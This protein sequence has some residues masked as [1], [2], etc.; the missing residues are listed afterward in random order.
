MTVGQTTGVTVTVRDEFGNPVGGVT[1]TLQ[2]SGAVAV[3][4]A[5]GATGSNGQASGSIRAATGGAGTV[6]AA[7]NGQT[8]QAAQ[9]TVVLAGSTTDLTA[10]PGSIQAGE[11]VT[12]TASVSP[13]T[14][15]GSV[16][17]Q[18]GGSSCA[19]GAALGP[20][21]G[22]SSGSAS[23]ST[24]SLAAGTHRI[25]ACYSGD[26]AFTGSADEI[27]YTVTAAQVGTTTTVALDPPSPVSGQSVVVNVSVIGAADAGPV[28]GV[29]TVTSNQAGDCSISL[30]SQNSCA[31]PQVVGPGPL[32]VNA[33]YGGSPQYAPSSGQ[34]T[35]QIAAIPTTTSI[36]SD[37]PDPSTV[38]AD[39]LVAFAVSSTDGTP[40]GTVRVTGGGAECTGTLTDGGG[41]CTLRPGVAGD[42]V[43]ITAQYL[44]QAPHAGSSATE[45]HRVESPNGAPNALGDAY[46]TSEDLP[47]SI[48]AAGVLAND[49]D[50]EGDPL[51]AV[52][53]TVSANGSLTLSPAGGFGY[54]PAADFNGADRFTYRAR[55]PAGALSPPASV[56]LTVHPVNDPP[57]FTA[58]GDVSVADQ[59]GRRVLSG[60]ATA[61][62]A[63]PPDE[64]GQG[65]AFVVSTDDDAAF[66]G[67]P[68]IGADGTL[69][70]DP[71]PLPGTEPVVVTVTVRAVDTGGTAGGGD[72]TSAP[73]TFT[74]TITP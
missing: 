15:S 54:S 62:S 46:E 53:A 36:A 20:A 6:T 42:D 33:D 71:A 44:G 9:V 31:L 7:F 18:I 72:D 25:R 51:V 30:P 3:E 27:D 73:Q 2:T 32:T 59:P 28:A 17:F 47:L 14:A 70:F 61:I 43:T 10:A 56:T 11:S 1:P 45:P 29:V 34:T 8:T 40:A 23:F 48:P 67:R 74:I 49:A 19:D 60:W 21:V 5:P 69:G 55:D 66:E 65:V 38:G 22:L 57:S 35:Q 39:V 24:S 68:E 64:G 16:L 37:S 41:S 58:G 4:A 63:G 13:G 12:F 52:A 50:P 26:G